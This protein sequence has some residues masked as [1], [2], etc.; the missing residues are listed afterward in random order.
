MARFFF[1][2]D[3]DG[4]KIEV[5]QRYRPLPLRRSMRNDKLKQ[6]G[7]DHVAKR[8]AHDARS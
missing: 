5:L 3:P 6:G 8:N 7:N 2:E 4:Y 1:I